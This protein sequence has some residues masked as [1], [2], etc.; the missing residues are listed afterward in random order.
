MG[1]LF[2]LLTVLLVLGSFVTAIKPS[3]IRQRSRFK[4][5]TLCWIAACITALMGSAFD[6][7]GS[8]FSV[9]WGIIILLVVY[10]IFVFFATLIR[11]I[12]LSPEAR[13]EKIDEL[14]RKQVALVAEGRA[15]LGKRDGCVPVH[16]E[17][18][19]DK[20]NDRLMSDSYNSSKIK[21]NSGCVIDRFEQSLTVLWAGN[22]STVEFTYVSFDGERS[23][24]KVDVDEL[25]FN[26]RGQFYLRGLCHKRQEQRTF[27]VDNIETQL[28]VGSKRY[29]FEDWCSDVIGLSPNLIED[30]KCCQNT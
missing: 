9:F 17:N 21:E 27:K 2:A 16:S 3:L 26:E 30:V 28:K 25:S 12:R 24:R 8:W 7:R 20:D 29:E 5:F 22:K 23:R 13:Q 18:I 11:N 14:K 15:L 6:G 4:T 10:G 1:T 19:F